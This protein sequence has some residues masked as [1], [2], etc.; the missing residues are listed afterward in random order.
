MAARRIL[1]SFWLSASVVAMMG[2]NA[3]VGTE[4]IQYVDDPDTVEPD[5]ETETP[6]PGA[7][8]SV[9]PGADGGIDASRDAH[10]DA[11]ADARFSTDHDTIEDGGSSDVTFRD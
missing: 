10:A 7:D 11:D 9:T 4:D 8:S 3:I 2:C 1:G 6:G 5:D